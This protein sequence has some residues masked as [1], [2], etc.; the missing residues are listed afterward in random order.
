MSAFGIR[1]STLLRRVPTRTGSW[2][3]KIAD[4]IEACQRRDQD[5]VLDTSIP[6]YLSQA[7][8]LMAST[9]IILLG[10]LVAAW[11]ASDQ[12]ARAISA[13]PIFDH[14]SSFV[15]ALR[16]LVLLVIFTYAFFKF[17][18]GIRMYNCVAIMIGA[19]PPAG[20][21]SG[22]HAAAFVDGATQL[23]EVG[24]ETVNAGFRAYYLGIAASSWLVH[25]WLCVALSSLVCVIL[26]LREFSGSAL[27]GVA[28]AKLAQEAHRV[29]AVQRHS[30]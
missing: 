23:A 18:L 2:I 11:S 19:L 17:S 30:G 12:I 7:P 13:L 5:R 27:N 9:T 4:I 8:T 14:P 6:S 20:R 28:Y 15:W 3:R 10:S 29:H 16:L 22:E 25:P 26:Y 21:G 1:K 24:G